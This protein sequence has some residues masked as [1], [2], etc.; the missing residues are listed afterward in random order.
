MTQSSATT[1][2]YY[3]QTGLGVEALAQRE[4]EAWGVSSSRVLSGGL[5]VRGNQELMWRLCLSSRLIES[6]RIRLKA[7]VA[8]DFAALKEGVRRLPLSAFLEKGAS[9]QV[10]V[11]CKKS[12]LWHSGAVGQRVGEVLVERF[13][14]VCVGDDSPKEESSFVLFV[15]VAEDEVQLSLEVSGSRLHRR[16]YRRHTERASLRE[17]LAAALIASAAGE[18]DSA[19]EVLWDPCAGA[20]TIPLEALLW[21]H[22]RLSGAERE[23]AFERFRGFSS[24]AFAVFRARL[25]EEVKQAAPA[26]A[27]RVIASDSSAGALAS[28]QENLQSADL[29]ASAQLIPGSIEEV[30]S[31]VPQGAWVVTNPPYG[32]RLAESQALTQLKMVLKARPDLRPVVVLVGEGARRALGSEPRAILRTKNGGVSV[33]ARLLRS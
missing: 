23:F 30:A 1:Y 18:A 10:R 27:L 11:L 29:L 4:V 5:E 26:P 21:G 3:A 13:G 16:G 25:V 17:T 8:R 2:L 15:R 33:S 19:P 24:D 9:I 7:F 32:K 22:G 28:A 14:L 12:R 6:V 20:G 31:Q